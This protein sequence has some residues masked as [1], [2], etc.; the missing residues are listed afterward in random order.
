MEIVTD[1]DWKFCKW[2]REYRVL[3][4]EKFKIGQ[5]L[6]RQFLFLFYFL[7]HDRKCP[8]GIRHTYNIISVALM[9]GGVIGGPFQA[10]R[11]KF[12]AFPAF[13]TFFPFF[14]GFPPFFIVFRVFF[15]FSAAF[16]NSFPVS[17]VFKNSFPFSANIFK[18]FGFL[19]L[20]NV[21]SRSPAHFF[22]LFS[23]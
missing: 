14:S 9:R 16:Q 21:I 15:R 6:D 13:R 8:D 17:A 20:K 23:A 4:L 11:G 7:W 1:C 3:L 12:C 2:R 5:E 18:F 22:F 19:W 10:F